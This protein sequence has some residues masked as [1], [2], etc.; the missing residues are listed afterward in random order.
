GG[1][2]EK[3]ADLC[4]AVAVEVRP[5][6]GGAEAIELGDEFGRGRAHHCRTLI[7]T[8][9][10]PAPISSSSRAAASERSMS[11]PRMKGPRSLMRTTTHR[12]VRQTRTRVPKGSMRCA[13]VMALGLK[14]S[15]EAVRWPSLYHEAIS[16]C[17]VAQAHSISAARMARV[18]ILIPC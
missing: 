10:T 12:P 5:D 13:A 4:L 14:R 11:R 9:P 3:A 1:S 18:S 17:A 6:E 8:A 16:A 15:P 2:W 7:R